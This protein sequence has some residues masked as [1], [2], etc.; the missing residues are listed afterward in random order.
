MLLQ[1]IQK[2]LVAQ[3]VR[4]IRVTLRLMP[5]CGRRHVNEKPLGVIPFVNIGTIMVSNLSSV[6]AFFTLKMEMKKKKKKET[7]GGILFLDLRNAL[8]LM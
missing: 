4:V 7:H 1:H 5:K 6:I 2:F 3:D 8:F